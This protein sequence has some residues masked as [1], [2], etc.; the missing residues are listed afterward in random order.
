MNQNSLRNFQLTLAGA[1]RWLPF[2]ALIWLLGLAGLGWLVKSFLILVGFICLAPVIAFLGFRWWL[3]RNLVQAQCPVCGTE[4]A[5][6]NQT[7]IE[8][9]SCG[10][11]L[12]VEKGHL[13]RLTPPGTIDVQAIEVPAQPMDR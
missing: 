4:V 5:G 8:C 3:K 1:S 2:L 10:E 13:S 11:A 9:S 12:K 7:Q 6:I